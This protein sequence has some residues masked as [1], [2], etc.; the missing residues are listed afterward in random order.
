MNKDIYLIIILIFY[1]MDPKILTLLGFSFIIFNGMSPLSKKGMEIVNNLWSL[2]FLTTL[3]II[4]KSILLRIIVTLIIIYGVFMY[5]I[6]NEN[7][8]NSD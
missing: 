1:L 5:F 8:F 7:I 2:F 6:K 4:I 3:A